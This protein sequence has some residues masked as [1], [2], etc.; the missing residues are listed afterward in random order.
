[1][2]G[3]ALS[4][5]HYPMWALDKGMT[6]GSVTDQQPRLDENHNEEHKGFVSIPYMY[7]SVTSKV[8][9]KTLRQA[10]RSL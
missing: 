7:V 10:S 4:D 1:M 9:A 5:C 2:V 6:F 8:L 3:T